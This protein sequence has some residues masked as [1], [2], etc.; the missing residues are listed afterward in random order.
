MNISKLSLT[1]AGLLSLTLV[2][3]GGGGGESTSNPTTPPVVTEPTPTPTPT[4]P[5]VVDTVDLE[6][7]QDF[8]FRTD[9]DLTLTIT[10]QPEY[11]GIV[12]VYHEV[13]YEDEANGILIPK[14]ETRVL[15]FYPAA[16]DNV[17][18]QVSKNWTHLIVEFIP[19]EAQG[20]EMYKKLELSTDDYLS[21]SFAD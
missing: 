18:I 3:C 4:E 8:D 9:M 1:L 6:V 10:E 2:G 15:S 20:T 19:T 5:E 21:F 12:N 7:S 17:E 13:E 14:Y 11:A 16:T